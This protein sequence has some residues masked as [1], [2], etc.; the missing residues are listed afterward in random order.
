MDIPRG[1]AIPSNRRRSDK[2]AAASLAF[3]SDTDTAGPPLEN[4]NAEDPRAG[5]SLPQ[6][7]DHQ[8]SAGRSCACLELALMTSRDLHDRRSQP[9]VQDEVIDALSYR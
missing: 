7:R 5:A 1:A 2:T 8:A 9:S 4:C 3:A 6:G